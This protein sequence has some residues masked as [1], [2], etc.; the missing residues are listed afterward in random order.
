M[1]I[2][3][4]QSRRGMALVMAMGLVVVLAAAA[5]IMADRAVSELQQEQRR[6]DTTITY[7]STEAGANTAWDWLKDATNSNAVFAGSTPPSTVT[8]PSSIA[9]QTMNDMTITTTC[10]LTDSASRTYLLRTVG[11]N[12]TDMNRR[13]RHCVEMRLD[14]EVSSVSTPINVFTFGMFAIDGWT[15]K[16]SAKTNSW[17]STVGLYAAAT[18]GSNGDVGSNGTMTVAKPSN[19]KGDAISNANKTFPMPDYPAAADAPLMAPAANRLGAVATNKTLGDPAGADTI[20]HCT[21][22]AN[23]Q[24]TI[25]GTGTTTIYC[26]GAINLD[27]A[28]VYSQNGSRLIIRQGPGTGATN[29]NGN[30]SAGCIKDPSR[31]AVISAYTGEI[32]LNGNASMGGVFYAPGATYK[33]NG[34]FDLYGAL[35]TKSFYSSQV[36]GSFFFHYDDKLSSTPFVINASSPTPPTATNKEFRSYRLTAE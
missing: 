4:S 3:T 17:N 26:D 13:V 36:N 19:I 30:N 6:E 33:C 28:I 12:N 9:T 18:A 1:F 20:Y 22:L 31:Y 2:H 21:S 25:Q 10:V 15:I 27:T 8:F 24:L 7:L 32:T 5:T 29:L 35:V 14:V 34:T 11:T 23:V 16:G